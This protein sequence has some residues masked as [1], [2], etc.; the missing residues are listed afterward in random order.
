LCIDACDNV[1]IKIGRPTGLIAYDTDENI[2]RRS[3]GEPALKPKIFRARTIVYMVLIVAVAG[4]MGAKLATRNTLGVNVM[5]DRNPIYVALSDGSIRNAYTLRILNQ[6]GFERD[7]KLTLT[8]LPQAT[9]EVQ[10][11]SAPDESGVDITVSP[12]QTLELRVLV[13]APPGAQLSQ[14]TNVQFVLTDAKTAESVK[15]KDFFKSP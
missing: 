2:R 11:H 3:V 15:Q 5:H 7:F 10:G 14:S 13:T 12:D 6:K 8:G 4:A 9:I 1:M